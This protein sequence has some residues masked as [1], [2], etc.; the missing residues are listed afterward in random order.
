MSTSAVARHSAATPMKDPAYSC[1]GTMS[2]N[3]SASCG[4]SAA[5]ISVPTITSE[6]AVLACPGGTHS[7][8]AKRCCSW[9]ARFEPST[10]ADAQSSTKSCRT[11]DQAIAHAATEASSA[12]AMNARRRPIRCITSAAGIVERA[13]PRM[14][15]ETG[16]VARPGDGASWLPRMPPSSVIVIIPEADSACA[17]VST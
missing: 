1:P 16:S 4:P 11:T 14:M 6:M 9:N 13:S 7:A 10:S 12:L 3:A 5:A 15:Q 17:A 2:F 8:A